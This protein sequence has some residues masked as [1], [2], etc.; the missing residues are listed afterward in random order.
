[1]CCFPPIASNVVFCVLLV[2]ALL[3]SF[4][5][6]FPRQ[7]NN[8][9]VSMQMIHFIPLLAI[10]K[11]SEAEARVVGD[12]GI[13]KHSGGLGYRSPTSTFGIDT[14]AYKRDDTVH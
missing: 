10:S 4:L 2:L 5:L 8:Q 7:D 11:T 3:A 13:F 12:S 6:L 14:K 9:N 1:M